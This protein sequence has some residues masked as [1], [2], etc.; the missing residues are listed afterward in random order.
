VDLLPGQYWY[1]ARE[2]DPRGFALYQR[3]YSA[4]RRPPGRSKHF[5]GPGEKMVLLTPTADA[6]FVWRLERPG[7]RRDGLVGV[8]C[9]VFRNEGPSRSSALILE[10]ERL[11]WGRWPGQTL[12]TH[13]R[14]DAVASPVPGWCFIRARWKRAG[15]S[16]NG[17][18]LFEKRPRRP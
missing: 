11:A 4:K 18:L 17:L 2:D 15:E 5:V 16:A 3:H 10:A 9:V 6:L 12:L 1:S 8:Y 14:A 7:M 13:V